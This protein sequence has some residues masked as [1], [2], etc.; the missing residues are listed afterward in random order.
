MLFLSGSLAGKN[1]NSGWKIVVHF[2]VADSNY[3]V[4]PGIGS[5]FHYIFKTVFFNSVYKTFALLNLSTCDCMFCSGKGFINLKIVTLLN[6]RIYFV[7]CNTNKTG[8]INRHLN[9]AYTSINSKVLYKRFVHFIWSPL[10]SWQH[11]F[12]YCWL[13]F[14]E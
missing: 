10:F 14:Q 8:I 4:E 13:A 5:S 1:T 7:L 2:H 9:K 3:S 6:R 12:V 11:I